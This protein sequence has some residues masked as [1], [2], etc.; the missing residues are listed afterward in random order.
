MLA[1]P[2]TSTTP[3]RIAPGIGLVMV[4]PGNMQPDPPAGT[5]VRVAVGPI[6]KSG[7]ADSSPGNTNSGVTVGPGVSVG[8]IGVGV[9]GNP[10]R[11]ARFGARKALDNRTAAINAANRKIIVRDRKSTR[12]NST[13]RYIS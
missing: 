6:C 12:L 4:A 13:H 10:K 9:G 11:S 3:A 2:R 7:V 1:V 5:G 8:S